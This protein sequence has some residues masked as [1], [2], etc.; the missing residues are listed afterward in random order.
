MRKSS[1][2]TGLGRDLLGRIACVPAIGTLLAVPAGQMGR[3]KRF[4]EWVSMFLSKF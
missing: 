4:N 2:H 1:L 3:A